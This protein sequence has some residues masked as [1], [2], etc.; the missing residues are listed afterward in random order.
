MIEFRLLEK[1]PKSNRIELNEER[2]IKNKKKVSR[3]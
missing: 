1:T 2:Q 3:N